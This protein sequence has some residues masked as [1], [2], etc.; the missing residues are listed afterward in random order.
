LESQSKYNKAHSAGYSEVL[1]GRERNEERERG[2]LA[3]TYSPAIA[4]GLRK[5]KLYVA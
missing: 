4:Q 5:R 2:E 1:D 3:L